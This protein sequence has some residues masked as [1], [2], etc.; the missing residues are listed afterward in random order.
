[1]KK[2]I[3]AARALSIVVS[4]ALFWAVLAQAEAAGPR[5]YYVCSCGPKCRCD[6]ISSKPGKC[7][8]DRR[9]VRMY[10]LDIKGDTAS[11]CNC[12]K[13]CN[14]A[15]SQTNPD[16]CTCGNPVKK[17]S[18]KGKYVCDCGPGCK[19]G[20][21]SEKPGKCGCGKTLRKVM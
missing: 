11:F 17:V 7:V 13:S 6:T 15:I 1:M 10:L 9:T 3:T 20:T 12:E 5:A 19:C 8:C 21:I 16:Q 14:C 18:L 2:L 4:C